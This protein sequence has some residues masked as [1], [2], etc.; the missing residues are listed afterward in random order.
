MQLVINNRS[1]NFTIRLGSEQKVVWHM[2]YNNYKPWDYDHFVSIVESTP[3][4]QVGVPIKS[5]NHGHF[6][7]ISPTNQ[8]SIQCNISMV[9]LLS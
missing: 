9:L 1:V 8:P 2:I 7:L 3:R 5:R 4:K 6:H